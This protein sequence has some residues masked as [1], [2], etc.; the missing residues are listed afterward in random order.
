MREG[1][2]LNV[3]LS[4]LRAMNLEDLLGLMVDLGLDTTKVTERTHA[5][6]KIVDLAV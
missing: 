5:L 6:T 1:N 2:F 3:E 4:V